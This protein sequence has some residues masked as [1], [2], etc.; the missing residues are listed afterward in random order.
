[1]R[2]TLSIFS[3]LNRMSCVL[4]ATL[5]EMVHVYALPV[6]VSL[7]A[8]VCASVTVQLLSITFMPVSV[9]EGNV[10]GV[11]NTVSAAVIVDSS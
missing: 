10:I 9:M 8:S 4:F 1:M 6:S 2:P 7:L 11:P 3:R 5:P